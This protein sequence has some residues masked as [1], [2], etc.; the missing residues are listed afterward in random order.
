MTQGFSGR[1]WVLGGRNGTSEVQDRMKQGE[2]GTLA[3]RV[4]SVHERRVGS[5]QGKV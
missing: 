4:R 5:T 1:K 2:H 3:R